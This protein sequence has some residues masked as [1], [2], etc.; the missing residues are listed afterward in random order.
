MSNDFTIKFSEF[1]LYETKLLEISREELIKR[2]QSEEIMFLNNTYAG[3]V[4]FDLMTNRDIKEWITLDP[5]IISVEFKNS[6]N[7][8]FIIKQKTQY[9]FDRFCVLATYLEDELKN[10]KFTEKIGG[11]LNVLKKTLLGI[12][13]EIIPNE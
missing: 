9:L 11:I 7:D 3:D 2:C 4:D 13:G 12:G 10:E 8:L 6:E 5:T 1:S